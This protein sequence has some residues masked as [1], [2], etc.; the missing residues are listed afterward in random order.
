MEAKYNKMSKDNRAPEREDG[1]YQYVIAKGN[2]SA[3][4]RKVLATRENWVEMVD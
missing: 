3:L 4:V 1:M 2:N